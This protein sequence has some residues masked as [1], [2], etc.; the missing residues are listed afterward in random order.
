MRRAARI[1][2][3]MHARIFELVEPGLPKNEL[4]AEIYRTAIR[5]ADGHGG[6]YPA[7][8]PLLPSGIDASAPHLTWDERPFKKDEGAF[9]EIAGCYRRYHCPLSRTVWLGRPPQ[10]VLDT[11]KAILEGI[12]AA[13]E[14]T[15]PGSTCEDV[16]AA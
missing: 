6:D 5:G 1:A 11:E 9:V 13:L 14:A 2:E 10:Q 8:V 3:A 4:V 16:D 15:R 7:I 12:E